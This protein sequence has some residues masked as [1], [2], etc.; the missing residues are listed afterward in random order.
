[1]RPFQKVTAAGFSLG[2]SLVVGTTCFLSTADFSLFTTAPAILIVCL[3]AF[4]AAFR[5]ILSENTPS[6][7]VRLANLAGIIAPGFFAFHLIEK[8][9]TL[10]G[11]ALW[12]YPLSILIIGFGF[13]KYLRL[14]HAS[15]PEPH[16][17]TSFEILIVP[18]MVCV[19]ALIILQRAAMKV[20][21]HPVL[22][23]LYFGLMFA[24]F[25]ERLNTTSR[26]LASAGGLLFPLLFIFNAMFFE[27]YSQ[28]IVVV[29]ITFFIIGF[30]DGTDNQNFQTHN[31]ELSR[32]EKHP[33]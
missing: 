5:N 26:N 12:F 25:A 28:I 8:F 24:L 11:I 33:T 18:G 19:L 13:G 31:K 2:F 30:L 22:L 21:P 1:M 29:A 4:F 23:N 20:P 32:T 7:M 14:R 6:A 27:H 10:H 3:Y 15:R 16:D 9:G 17:T